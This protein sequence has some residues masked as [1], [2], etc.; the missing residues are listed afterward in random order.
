MQ[1]QDCLQ[2]GTIIKTHGIHGEL[3]LEANNS[4]LIENIKESVFLEIEGLLV[5]FFIEKI[6]AHSTV[7]FRVKFLWSDSETTSKKIIGAPVFINSSLVDL[8]DDEYLNTPDLLEGFKVIDNQ[9][10]E[11]GTLIQID[12]NADNPLMIIQKGSKELLIP[13]HS[14]IIKKVKSRKKQ[15]HIQTPDGLIDLYL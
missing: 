6:S 1:K 13:F 8:E 2:I 5:P 7:R 15:I 10:G 12:M 14:D 3:I 4:G 11:I 9:H